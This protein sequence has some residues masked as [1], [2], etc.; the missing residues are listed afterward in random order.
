MESHLLFFL[1]LRKPGNPPFITFNIIITFVIK[2]IKYL[3][4]RH[5]N[6]NIDSTLSVSIK[7]V[8][9]L[10]HVYLSEKDI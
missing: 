1:K 2:F 8:I 10:D 3:K 4:L 9:T 5:K 7:S 6:K